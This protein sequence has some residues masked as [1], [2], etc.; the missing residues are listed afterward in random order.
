MI[1]QFFQF[2]PNLAQLG[3]GPGILVLELFG[4]RVSIKQ[5]NMLA[6]TQQ[7]EMLRLSVHI[8]QPLAH[9][10]QQTQGNCASVKTADVAPFAPDF[11]PK[12]QVVG[13]VEERFLFQDAGHLIPNDSLQL[14][15][16]LNDGYLGSR[17]NER[18]VSASAQQHLD[19][20]N[21]D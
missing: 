15:G 4:V 10:S 19:G 18:A 2:P 3:I 12:D 6:D 20:V 7:A 5:V 17:A 16:T 11:P 8:H 21:D 9:L 14:E 13:V 1:P